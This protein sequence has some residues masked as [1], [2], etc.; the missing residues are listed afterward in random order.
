MMLPQGGHFVQSDLP[1]IREKFSAFGPPRAVAGARARPE[2]W[3]QPPPAGPT[4]STDRPG[5]PAAATVG[6]C[7]RS[8]LCFQDFQGHPSSQG[9]RPTDR[10]GPSR[11]GR[12]RERRQHRMP[13]KHLGQKR[14]PG[15]LGW[16]GVSGQESS[17]Q[18][19]TE[20]PT[21]SGLLNTI[22]TEISRRSPDRPTGN[23]AFRGTP[24]RVF[25][26]PLRDNIEPS[27]P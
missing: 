22:E 6:L 16:L 11:P 23:R 9:A 17:R 26:A 3:P 14:V 8:Y 12:I 7:A 27:P 1:K 24:P 21:V 5:S 4:N 2:I 10:P 20:R 13:R 18:K 25:Q 19:T 15:G